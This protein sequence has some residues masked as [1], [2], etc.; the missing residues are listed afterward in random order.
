LGTFNDQVFL[1]MEFIRG[2][3]LRSWL[4]EARRS[5]TEILSIFLKAGEGLRAAH[6]SGL[7]HRDFKADNVLVGLEGQVRVT[8]FG[9]AYRLAPPRPMKKPGW[10]ATP[11]SPGEGRWRGRRSTSR[12]SKGAVCPPTRDR[13]NSASAFRCTRR[14]MASGPTVAKPPPPTRAWSRLRPREA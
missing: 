1:A 8:D 9:L 2:R 10:A 5:W 11:P 4:G 6:D 12:P 3:D 13:I 7:V 14:S